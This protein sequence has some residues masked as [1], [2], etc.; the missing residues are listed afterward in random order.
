MAIALTDLKRTG[1]IQSAFVLDI[2][3]HY[4]DGN[5]NI[6]E[7]TEYTTVFNVESH[8]RTIYLTEVRQ[9]MESC[10][11]D[12][13]G[14]SAGFDNHREDWGGLMETEDYEE[15]GTY[16]RRAANRNG[17]GCFAILE[18]GYNHE[19]LGQNVLALMQGMSGA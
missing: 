5:V 17:G 10:K 11:A 19:V 13:I 3:L 4:S 6:L 7:Q 2:D 14:I 15:I 8:N 1:H 16:V 18:G 9:Q 12:I